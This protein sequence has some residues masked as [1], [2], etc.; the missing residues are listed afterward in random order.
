MTNG[1]LISATDAR[2]ILSYGLCAAIIAAALII[3]AAL[4]RHTKKQMR[5]EAVK[6][7]CVKAKKYAAGLLVQHKGTQMLLGAT[8]LAK[9][10]AYISE[11][12]WLAFQIVEAKKDIVFE[13]IA[14]TLDGLAT[15]VSK[16]SENGYIPA[17]EYEAD[18]KKAI[19][20]LDG[21]IAKIDTLIKR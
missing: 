18:V 8:K 9:L 12:A 5:P 21:V 6:K 19:A 7:S 20:G 15:E 11:A 3:I 10:N 16:E 4:K 17:E 1:L 13:G 14:G 2:L